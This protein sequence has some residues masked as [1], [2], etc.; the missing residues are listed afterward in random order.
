MADEATA[1]ETNQ[2]V[3]NEEAAETQEEMVPKSRLEEEAAKVKAAEEKNEL[4]QQNQALIQANVQATA[5]PKRPEFDIYKEVGLDPD[6]PKDIPNQEQQKKINAY[7]HA[8]YERD[9]AQI[10]FMLDHPD[11]SQI[12][13]T[14][15]QIRTGQFAEPLKQA[16]KANPALMA[17]IQNSADPQAAAYAIAKQQ[18]N[19]T[20]AGDTTKTT[21][22]E[23]QAAIDEAVANAGAVKTSANAKG[24][25][26]LSEEGRAA[27][28]SDAEFMKAF[29]ASGGD[30]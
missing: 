30:L 3:E 2:A 25:D 5:A 19:K 27:N 14:A 26:G 6:D 11:Y 9:N 7:F 24:G 29:N 16:I 17:T 8:K 12:V 1:N 21:K 13:G 10:R 4:L 28:M 22:T 18:V 20:A 15:E 23:A